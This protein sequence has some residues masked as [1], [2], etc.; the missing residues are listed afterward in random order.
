MTVS[1]SFVV[2][3]AKRM[4]SMCEISGFTVFST[5]SH[6][7]HDIRENVIEHKIIFYFSLQTV[8]NISLSKK[9]SV[10]YCYKCI[11]VFM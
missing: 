6:K 8:R 3:H 2:Q 7:G 11:S 9:N 1:V 4:C 10:R 5:L